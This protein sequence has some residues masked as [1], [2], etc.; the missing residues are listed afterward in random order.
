MFKTS[1]KIWHNTRTI[2]LNHQ[3]FKTYFKTS[4][5]AMWLLKSI[6]EKAGLLQKLQ[7]KNQKYSSI[8]WG[9]GQYDAAFFLKIKCW[10]C[11]LIPTICNKVWSSW[12]KY[13]FKHHWNCLPFREHNQTQDWKPIHNQ[14]KI[15]NSPVT[16]S[17]RITKGLPN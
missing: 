17:K 14:K 12:I 8:S 2:P 11:W 3:W 9:G 7:N 13:N 16:H 15:N 5:F 1:W 6:N 10:I 4:D